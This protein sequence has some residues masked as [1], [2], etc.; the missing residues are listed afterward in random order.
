MSPDGETAADGAEA[1]TYAPPP[2]PGHSM[3]EWD[4]AR[5]PDCGAGTLVAWVKGVAYRHCSYIH[6]DWGI[7]SDVIVTPEVAR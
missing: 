4:G 5:C 6:C 2:D 3:A 1:T 7:R